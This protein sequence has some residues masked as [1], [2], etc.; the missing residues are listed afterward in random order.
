M[1]HISRTRK[2]SSKS[3]NSSIFSFS[4]FNSALKETSKYILS[5]HSTKDY[6]K[7]WRIGEFRLCTRCIGIYFGILIGAL[8]Y[9]LGLL[10]GYYFSIISIFPI[11]MFLDW[12]LTKKKITRSHNLIRIGTGALCGIAYS[13]GLILLVKEQILYVLAPGII[14]TLLG[15][16]GIIST[17]E[18]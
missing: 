4:E 9:Y 8:I 14:Y 12:F 3:T 10:K 1:K 2:N 13:L 15:A 17:R 7:C 6:D 16:F 5:H 18:R 11:F